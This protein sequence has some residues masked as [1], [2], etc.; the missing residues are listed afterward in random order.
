M[1]ESPTE[2]SPAEFESAYPPGI[3]RHFWTLAR[4]RVVADAIRSLPG[5]GGKVLEIGCGRGIV[6][7]N[8]REQGLECF[9]VEV[10]DVLV[11]PS[12]A[13]FVTVATDA[14]QLPA[15]FRAEIRTILLLDVIEHLADPV[16][17]ID[18]AIVHYPNIRHLVVTVPARSELWSN[19][20]EFYRHY[21]RYDLDEVRKTLTQARLNVIHVA[22]FFHLLYPVM[23]L[24][25]LA[26]CRATRVKAPGQ[27]TTVLHAGLGKIL[28]WDCTLLPGAWYGTSAIGIA[29]NRSVQAHA[30]IET[31]RQDKSTDHGS[32]RRNICS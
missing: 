26:A 16:A 24:M 7:A 29:T 5:C 4:S 13:E 27:W 20:D 18:D 19:Y 30:T 12:V 21:R 8:L 1:L 25:K 10:A 14:R 2:F 32:L 15:K 11:L 6:V 23:L 31:N 22:Y 3:E 28:H 9:G 17:F